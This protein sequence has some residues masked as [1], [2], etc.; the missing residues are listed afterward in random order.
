[1]TSFAVIGPPRPWMR[2]GRSRDGRAYDD[3]RNA[4]AKRDIA[5]EARQAFREPAKGP[6]HLHLEFRLRKPKKKIR[7]NSTPFPYPDS[8]PDVDNLIKL[9]LDAFNGVVYEDDRQVVHLEAVKLW[10]TAMNPEG[11]YV[12]VSKMHA[13]VGVEAKAK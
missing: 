4:S 11:T 7:K 5:W 9:C 12:R 8:K 6:I 1:M 2:A 13:R 3:P 10:A